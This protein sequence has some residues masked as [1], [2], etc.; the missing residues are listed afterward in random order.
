MIRQ[1][2]E[3]DI[4]EVAAIERKIFSS[5]WSEKSF[6]D[7]LQSEDNIYLVAVE[8]GTIVGYCGIWTSYETGDLCN[9]AVTPDYRRC[10][11]GEKLLKE[12]IR[13]AKERQVQSLLLEVRES[14]S[15]A[16]ALYKKTGFQNIGIRKEYY[17]SPKED[18][19]LMQ[20]ELADV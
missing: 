2:Q 18:A 14:N 5:P 1:M 7:A 9:I 19:L 3:W 12:A 4:A 13:L 11:I 16:V 15:G 8:A 17:R 6:R 20:C 10:H